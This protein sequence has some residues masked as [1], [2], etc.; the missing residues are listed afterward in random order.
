LKIK[1]PETDIKLSN[2]SGNTPELENM[3][4]TSDIFI[5]AT[6]AAKHAAF[7]AVKNNRSEGLLYPK[8][9][10]ASSMIACLE[11]YFDRLIEENII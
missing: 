7:Y 11:E 6:G 4:R 9:K 10:G 5:F 2:A 8:G 1:Y 3:A